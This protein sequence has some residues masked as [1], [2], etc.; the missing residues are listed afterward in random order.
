MVESRDWIREEKRFHGAKKMGFKTL[1][2][3]IGWQHKEITRLTSSQNNATNI[4]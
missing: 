2:N 4:E 1:L 3:P